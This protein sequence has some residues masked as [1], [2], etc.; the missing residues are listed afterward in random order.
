[1]AY[2]RFRLRFRLIVGLCLSLAALAAPSCGGGASGDQTAS[3]VGSWT[4]ASG[5]LMP[6]CAIPGLSA[7]DLTGGPVVLTRV[8][9]STLQGTLNPT[10]VIKFHASGNKATVAAGQTCTFDLGTPVGPQTIDIT[11]WTLTLAG[12]R[13]DCTIAGS[14]IGCTAMG[15]GVLARDATTDGGAPD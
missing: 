2:S 4:F 8:D 5:S 13:I 9:D 14:A 3:F 6:M 15:T 11:T 10:C 12:D 1:M 7:L